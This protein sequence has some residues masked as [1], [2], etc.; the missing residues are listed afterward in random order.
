MCPI[1]DTPREGKTAERCSCV[2]PRQKQKHLA[3]SAGAQA[4]PVKFLNSRYT[5][6]HDKRVV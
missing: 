1:H 6:K 3:I 4:L 5:I 2:A